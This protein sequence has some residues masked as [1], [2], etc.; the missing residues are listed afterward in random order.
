MPDQIILAFDFGT[1]RIGC[2]VGYTS[3]KI[4]TPLTTIKAEK[5]VPHWQTL[6]GLIQKWAPQ[7]LVVGLPLNMDGSIQPI[8]N[9]AE[10]FAELLKKRYDLPVILSEERLTTV[11]ARQ[12][13]FDQG[14]YKAL[15]QMDIDSVAAQIILEEWLAKHAPN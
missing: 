6:D 3:T 5:G 14:G 13:I 10:N 12:R 15:Q 9:K 2:A 8:A 11:E 7:L 4:A 1:K